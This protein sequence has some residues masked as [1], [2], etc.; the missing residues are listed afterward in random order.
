LFN[1]RFLLLFYPLG[2]ALQ[3]IQRVADAKLRSVY[4]RFIH[5]ACCYAAD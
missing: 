1:I 2:Q 4:G 5:H 3:F